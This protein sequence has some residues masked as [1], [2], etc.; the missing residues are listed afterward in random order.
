MKR[1]RG[2]LPCASTPVSVETTSASASASAVVEAEAAEAVVFEEEPK[3]KRRKVKGATK[4]RGGARPKPYEG[5]PHVPKN[6]GFRVPEQ[7]GGFLLLLYSR[8]RSYKFSAVI[9]PLPRIRCIFVRVALSACPTRLFPPLLYRNCLI[10]TFL[11]GW[12][13]VSVHELH[14]A[15]GSMSAISPYKISVSI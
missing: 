13:F 9:P 10:I 5:N 3:L 14:A 11:D 6:N 12:F 8:F 15:S 2:P 1:E 7:L 4:T